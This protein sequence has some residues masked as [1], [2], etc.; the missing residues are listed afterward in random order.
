M[1]IEHQMILQLGLASLSPP[2]TLHRSRR[3]TALIPI[4]DFVSEKIIAGVLQRGERGRRYQ[5]VL[6]GL[7]SPELEGVRAALDAKID[8]DNIFTAGWMPG[9]NWINTPFWPICVGP[10]Q[11]DITWARVDGLGSIRT[12]FR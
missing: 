11:R 7:T 3:R 5:A 6:T 9:K 1:P 4:L 12:P 10:A 2:F 8:G